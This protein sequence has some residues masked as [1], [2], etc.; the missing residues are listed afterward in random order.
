[1]SMTG[2]YPKAEILTGRERRR[3]WS[4]AEKLEMVAETREPGVTVSLVA[5]LR[6]VAHSAT[7]RTEPRNPIVLRRRDSSAA[8]RQPA[9]H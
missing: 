4:V 6:R 9:V 5:R 7:A 1:M 8:L 3:R 2:S